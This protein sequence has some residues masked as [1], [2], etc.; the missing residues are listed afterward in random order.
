[1]GVVVA[2][3]VGI[4]LLVALSFFVS[5]NR[6]VGDRNRIGS[7][8]ATVDAEL[9]RRHELIPK[10]VEAVRAVAAH[11]LLGCTVE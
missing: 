3:V 4:P 8:W 11:T 10:L 1:M 9:Q 5:Y 7:S 6:I 2:I